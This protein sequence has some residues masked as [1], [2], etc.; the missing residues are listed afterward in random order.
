MGCE[1]LGPL[2][3]VVFFE[4]FDFAG[5]FVAAADEDLALGDLLHG[6]GEVVHVA[7]GIGNGGLGAA[8]KVAGTAGGGVDD[9]VFAVG[10]GDGAVG[11]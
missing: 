2:R 1:G 5:E 10:G 6:D 11:H 4:L 3:S 7:F 8:G 9:E